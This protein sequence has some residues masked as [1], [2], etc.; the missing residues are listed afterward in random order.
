MLSSLH[1]RSQLYITLH[2]L[3]RPWYLWCFV[4]FK[5]GSTYDKLSPHGV[6]I[7]H[8]GELL[9]INDEL[10]WDPEIRCHYHHSGM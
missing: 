3:Q 10:N 4:H 9:R 6:T 1:L 7:I 5:L 2:I 8:K